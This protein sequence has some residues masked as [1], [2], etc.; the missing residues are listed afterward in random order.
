MGGT[1]LSNQEIR[2]CL[3]YGPFTESIARLNLLPEWRKVLGKEQPDSRKR[4]LE[5]LV[6]FLAMRDDSSYQKPMKD[7][8]SRF[9]NNQQQV[10]ESVL[11]QDEGVFR[12]ACIKVLENLG[13][14][15][16]HIRAGFNPAVFDA[17]MVAFSENLDNI[18]SDIRDRY[19]LLLE[20]ET[21]SA[22]TSNQTTDA[23]AVL[24][25]FSRAREVLFG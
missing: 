19:H 15:P 9:M 7:F 12:E 5:L 4:D 11:A 23:N 6:R 8:L 14:K 13:G 17:V 24:Q 1:P 18:P 2:N 20:D 21:F 3:Y 16:F 10:S 22:S 25:R